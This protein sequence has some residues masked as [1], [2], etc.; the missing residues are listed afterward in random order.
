MQN[1]KLTQQRQIFYF[2][3]MS[4]KRSP[5]FVW[6]ASWVIWLRFAIVSQHIKVI[7]LIN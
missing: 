6:G 4:L 2:G 7:V 3:E 5:R 1:N